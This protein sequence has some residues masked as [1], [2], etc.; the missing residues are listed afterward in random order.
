MGGCRGVGTK[1]SNQGVALRGGG[2]AHYGD[3]LGHQRRDPIDEDTQFGAD[4]ALGPERDV[5]RHGFH[6]PVGQHAHQLAAL[7]VLGG[8]VVGQPQHA[9]AGDAGGCGGG[10][11]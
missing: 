10:I 2:S 7:S 4:V 5:Q 9:Q 11:V 3:M 6:L 1:G 8:P